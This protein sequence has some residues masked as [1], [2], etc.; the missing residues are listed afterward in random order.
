MTEDEVLMI[1]RS[2]VIVVCSISVVAYK[3]QS[4][5]IQEVSVEG[6]QGLSK[7]TTSSKLKVRVFFSFKIYNA[8]AKLFLLAPVSMQW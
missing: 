5:L 8:P 4:R 2:E 1:A 7:Q 6:D 3:T